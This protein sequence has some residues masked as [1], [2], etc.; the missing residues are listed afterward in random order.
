MLQTQRRR[1]PPLDPP[2][3]PP[4]DSRRPHKVWVR[5]LAT[6]ALARG[7]A[8]RW[9]VACECCCWADAELAMRGLGVLRASACVLPFWMTPVQ[10]E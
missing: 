8:E 4:R 5:C 9:E 10:G 3:V 2:L 6:G 1:L 7:Y